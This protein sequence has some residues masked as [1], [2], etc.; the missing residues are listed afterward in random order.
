MSSIINYITG[1]SSS[2]QQF[3]Y[4]TT[5]AVSEEPK[6]ADALE[7]TC[8]TEELFSCA[9]SEEAS[10]ASSKYLELDETDDV[11]SEALSKEH[12]VSGSDP[13]DSESR[14]VSD[15]LSEIDDSG[16]EVASDELSDIEDTIQNDKLGRKQIYIR[17]IN[18]RRALKPTHERH[19]RSGYALK[20]PKA[21]KNTEL[22]EWIKHSKE[23]FLAERF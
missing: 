15:R 18:H 10:E 5:V 2:L 8:E 12:K 9:A 17:E 19:R 6:N 22:Q 13:A 14:K 21:D 23:Q 16:S 1:V 11:A 4:P 7:E 3:F 20:N